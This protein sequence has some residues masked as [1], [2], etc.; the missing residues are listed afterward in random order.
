[1]KKLI[2]AFVSTIFLFSTNIA[3]SASKSSVSSS[4]VKDSIDSYD[5]DTLIAKISGVSAPHLDGDYLVFTAKNTARSIGIVFDFENYKI[6]HNFSLQ[7][8]I[9]FE[10]EVTN[11]WFYFIIQKPKKISQ[12]SYKLIID[13]LWTTDPN[14][15]RTYFDEEQGV[16]L[17]QILIPNEDPAITETL[18]S[19]LTHFVC[20]AESGKNIRLGGTFTNWDSWI[21]TMK[22]VY[23]GRYELDIPLPEGSYYYAYYE[24][25]KAFV[26]KTNPL[27]G[28]SSDGKVVSRIEVQYKK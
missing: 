9:N 10:G 28:Y 22:E 3:F 15:E 8:I 5:Y 19:G 18:S 7:K 24:G 27:K 6:I 14:N 2:F 23:P 1:M 11:S 4:D 13:G 17:S 26:D 25:I 21:Y 12:V 20:F 16:L